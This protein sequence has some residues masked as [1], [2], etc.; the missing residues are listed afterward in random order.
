MISKYKDGK[1]INDFEGVG[2]ITETYSF[3]DDYKI[4]IIQNM[5]GKTNIHFS[6][7]IKEW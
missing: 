3:S 6:L 2:T 1:F 5:C 7:L 4:S